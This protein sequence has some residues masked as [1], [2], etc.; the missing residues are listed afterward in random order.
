MKCDGRAGVAFF[1]G[2]LGVSTI[3]VASLGL[4]GV[5]SHK[6]AGWINFAQTVVTTGGIATPILAALGASGVVQAKIGNGFSIAVGAFY[7]AAALIIFN[8]EDKPRSAEPQT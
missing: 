7:I 4:S 3:V 8:S 6:T 5:L 1:L 2:G